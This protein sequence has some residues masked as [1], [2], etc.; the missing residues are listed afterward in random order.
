MTDGVP[1]VVARDL[2]KVYAGGVVALDG[3]DLELH[4]GEVLGLVGRNG[5]GKTTTLRLVTGQIAATRG[6]VAVMGLAAARDPIGVRAIVGVMPAEDATFERLTGREIVELMARLHGLARGTAAARAAQLLDLLGLS[7]RDGERLADGYSTGMRRKV[8]LACAL[9][10]APRVLLL[11]EPLSGLDP[12]AASIVR[13]LLRE[14]AGRGC[15]VLVSS[16]ALDTVERLCD[17]VVILHA[18]RA[19]AAGTLDELRA[20]AGCAAGDS[21]EAVFL[22]L[23]GGAARGAI[24]EWLR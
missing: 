4:A 20:R 1:A 16:H 11:D 8:L 24:P 14:L 17:R 21:L 12:G 7:A 19:C 3:L 5:A 23:T 18:G 2:A 15:A 22:A 9:V 6:T 10:H 13:R